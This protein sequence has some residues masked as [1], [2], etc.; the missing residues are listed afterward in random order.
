MPLSGSPRGGMARVDAKPRR[1]LAPLQELR[2]ST[3]HEVGGV[4]V[5]VP[6]AQAVGPRH[7]RLPACSIGTLGEV[8]AALDGMDGTAP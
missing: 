8:A 3:G 7:G 1:G 5:E 2:A 4:Q 6:A